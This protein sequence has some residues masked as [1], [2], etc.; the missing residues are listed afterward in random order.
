MFCIDTFAATCKAAMANDTDRQGAAARV[1]AEA[2]ET[3]GPDAII[4]AL[5]AAVPKGANIGE[6]IVHSSPELTMLYARIPA[7]FQ[8]G[9]HNHT[10]FANIAQL[11]GEEVNTRY[12]KDGDRLKVVEERTARVGTVLQLPADVIH[13][14]ANPG[15]EM[16]YALH[17]YGGDFGAI[18][19]ERSLWD[20]ESH[21]EMGFSFPALVQQSVKAMAR[22]HNDAGLDALVAAIPAAKP[23]VDNVKAGHADV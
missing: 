3:H 2:V 14:I 6:L 13:G 20:E 21:E 19:D 7:R 11:R 1:L 4:H 18:E 9:V 12:A 8:S 22:A 15:D 16:A 5:N 17:L 10:V 23:V